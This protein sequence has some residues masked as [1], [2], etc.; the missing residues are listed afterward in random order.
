V[1]DRPAGGGFIR[2]VRVEPD[3]AAARAWPFTLPAVRDFGR[4]EFHPGV[5]YLVGENGSGKSTV[6]EALAVALGMNAEGGGRNLHFATAD[7]STPL[8]DHLVVER[9]GRPRTDFFLRAESF[10]N[11]ASQIDELDRDPAGGRRVSE[12]YGGGSLHVRSHGESF[13]AT[14]THRFGAGGLYLLDEPESALSFRG[15]LSLL[16]VMKDLVEAGSQ[17]VI[18]TH[19][20]YV[21]AFPGALVYALDGDGV[22]AVSYDEAEPVVRGR[23]FLAAPERYLRHLFAD[24]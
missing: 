8:A 21:L 17:F 24:D 3:D 7:T 23:E 6:V 5:T 10:Y 12:S 15:C 19:S 20:P 1:A 4:R 9:S 13:L 14:L 18:A 2:A 16:R 11:V 22:R